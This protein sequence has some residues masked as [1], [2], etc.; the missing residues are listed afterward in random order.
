[1]PLFTN[2]YCSF[3]I[4]I[5]KQP[6]L[7]LKSLQYIHLKSVTFN[8]CFI[9]VESISNEFLNLLSLLYYVGFLIIFRSI[10]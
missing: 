2:S 8:H 10:K 3:D 7:L 5:K 4:V 6:F 1:M 9:Y